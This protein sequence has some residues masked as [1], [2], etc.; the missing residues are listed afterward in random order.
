MTLDILKVAGELRAAVETVIEKERSGRPALLEL[1]RVFDDAEITR[2]VASARTSWLLGLPLGRYFER[3]AAPARV[4]AGYSCVATD[5]SVVVSDRHGPVQY[6]VINVGFCVLEYGEEPAAQLGS[7]PIVLWREEELSIPD[8]TRRIPITG[9]VLAMR[10]MVAELE[11]ALRLIQHVHEPVLA[12][13][14]GTLI[15]WVL[16][17]QTSSLVQ[18]G[19][20]GYARA[21][22]EF[23]RRRTPVAG[24]ISYPGSRDIINVLR[25][26]ACD[27]PRLGQRVNCDDCLRRVA[28]GERVQACAIVPD[29]TDRWFFATLD[30][31]RLAPGERSACFRS[32]SSIL[33]QLPA[34]DRIVFFYLH[35]GTEVARVELPHWVAV[36]R[37]LLDFVHAV[38]WDQCS[39]A[40]GY[41]LALQE[42]HEQAA[43]HRE[44]RLQLA[45]L[46]EQFFA[47]NGFLEQRSA[48]ER[49][50]RVR[51]A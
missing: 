20:E 9:N 19:I 4:R 28:R 30:D 44:E 1:L 16:E 42:A 45:G 21:L 6:V 5:A 46:I 32:Q 49:S 22:G 36:D 48:K 8:G 47:R 40:R 34:D 3:I 39:R 33:D 13:Q 25:V 27:Y 37:D 43:V 35:T 10:R 51:Y 24:V 50:K 11:A 12:L 17:G 41:P 26:A 29:V 18:W 2:R 14:D 23:R 7:D 38:V 31:V 15:P